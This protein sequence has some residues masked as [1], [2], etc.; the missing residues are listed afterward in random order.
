MYWDFT[1]HSMR[2]KRIPQRK[3]IW[4]HQDPMLEVSRR[5]WEARSEGSWEP[6]EQVPQ[7]R[8]SFRFPLC[9]SLGLN[10]QV[11]CPRGRVSC[12]VADP[13][14]EGQSWKEESTHFYSFPDSRDGALAPQV[15]I[16][17]G[18]DWT[19]AFHSSTSPMPNRDKGIHINPRVV[20]W[21]R[22]EDSICLVTATESAK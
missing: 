8:K 6:E 18:R 13:E 1:P 22:G 20:W 7:M 21:I 16:S 9:S 3:K 12:L 2:V 5:V 19:S 15:K 4:K 10:T 14:G 11:T 17:H